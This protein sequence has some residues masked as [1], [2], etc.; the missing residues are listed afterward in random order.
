MALVLRTAP[1][2]PSGSPD[3][4]K[5]PPQAHKQNNEENFFVKNIFP[6]PVTWPITI[7]VRLPCQGWSAGTTWP[8]IP[9]RQGRID[10]RG[11]QRR[12]GSQ[13]PFLRG[14]TTEVQKQPFQPR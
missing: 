10:S 3:M 5:G 2:T 7:I 12:F 13:K 4:I 9:C 11:P 14:F 6:G 8:A 1:V